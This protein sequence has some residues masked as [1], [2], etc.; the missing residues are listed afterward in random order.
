M[1]S[2]PHR[3]P[4]PRGSGS[5]GARV[6]EHHHTA[7]EGGGQHQHEHHVASL[8]QQPS[9]PRG[10]ACYHAAGDGCHEHGPARR[11]QTAHRRPHPAP[12]TQ[13]PAPPQPGG[14]APAAGGG[15][16]GSTVAQGAGH[17]PGGSLRASGWGS[18][19]ESPIGLATCWW[20]SCCIW[21]GGGGSSRGP[22]AAARGIEHRR[23]HEQ[24]P[25]PAE[26]SSQ[27]GRGHLTRGAARVPA[28]GPAAPD[29]D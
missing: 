21:W 23:L 26:G 13:H 6:G 25:P 22:R 15:L 10:P 8:H 16:V 24:L 5:P 2:L 4:H 7:A 1:S 3:Q 19:I 28:A 11:P 9:S 20:G 17:S 12:S 27:P 18:G 29:G 14:P